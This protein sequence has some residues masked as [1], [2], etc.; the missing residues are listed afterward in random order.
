MNETSFTIFETWC[1]L[2]SLYKLLSY[3][4]QKLRKLINQRRGYI[5]KL[6]L[7]LFSRNSLPFQIG[8]IIEG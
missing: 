7:P 8:G 3:L 5:L 1:K 4:Y 2:L 6:S